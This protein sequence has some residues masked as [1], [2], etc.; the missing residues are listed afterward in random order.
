MNIQGTY[1]NKGLALTAKTAVGAFLRVTRVVGGSGHTTDVPNAVQLPEIQQTLA[2]GEARCAGDTAVLPVT[3]AAVGQK[4]TYTLTELGVYAE[5]PDEGEIL[6]SVYRLDEPV[7]IQA[8]S[9]TVLRFY[10]RQTVSEDGGATVLCSPA[11]LITESD[12]G[13]V[14]RKVL[15]T[16]APSRIVTVPMSELAAYLSQLPRLLTEKLTIKVS[17]EWIGGLPIL[18]FYGCGSLSIQGEGTAVIHG[19]IQ[20]C[21]CGCMVMLEN[22]TVK[23]TDAMA[24]SGGYLLCCTTAMTVWIA[25]CILVGQGKTAGIRA[26]ESSLVNVITCSVTGCTN[27]I[28]TTTNS[29]TTLVYTTKAGYANN[30]I[31]VYAYNGGVA[32][33]CE[34]IPELVG[35]VSNYKAGGIIIQRNGTLL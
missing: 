33:L 4:S 11:G 14:R 5:D 27:A 22:L 6:Y 8:G 1:T 13:P 30:S 9:D 25:G 29:L 12:C 21:N 34:G 7:T 16:G 20:I 3:L 19:G 35:G 28:E 32:F 10:L 2:V 26:S 24:E 17:G 31:G 23:A 15:A 18:G